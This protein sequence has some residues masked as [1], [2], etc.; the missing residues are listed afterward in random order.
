MMFNAGR[1]LHIN[2]S[3]GSGE[4]IL[5]LGCMGVGKSSALVHHAEILSL[6]RPVDSEDTLCLTPLKDSERNLREEDEE[7][8]DEEEED[9]EEE[10]DDEEDYDALMRRVRG[11]HIQAVGEDPSER[12]FCRGNIERK[13]NTAIE[14]MERPD[15]PTPPFNGP[16]PV[17]AEDDLFELPEPSFSPR[18]KESFIQTHRGERMKAYAVEKLIDVLDTSQYRKAKNI[19]IDE[20]QFFE[21]LP[22][23]VK[24]ST[25][26]GKNLVLAGLSGDYKQ[27][28]FQSISNTIPLC[29]DLVVLHGVCMRCPNASSSFTILNEETAPPRRTS[30]GRRF[31]KICPRVQSLSRI[32]FGLESAC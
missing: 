12:V 15:S 20:G 8:D 25:R 32:R 2:R 31:R 18:L 29:S 26:Q 13:M 23:F 17:I 9:E 28:P 11:I 30:L 22:Q 1:R 14:M 5:Y 3:S 21:D 7:E 16:S 10:E 6:G 4:A 27:E 24:L 19:L